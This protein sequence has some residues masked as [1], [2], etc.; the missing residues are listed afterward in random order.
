MPVPITS[1]YRGTA[2]F[3]AP[4]ASGVSHPTVGIRRFSAAADGTTGYQHRVTGV[5]DL[6]YLSWRYLGNS[7]SWWRLADTTAIRFPLDLRPGDVVAVPAD[8]QP[9]Q[10]GR[11]RSF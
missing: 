8:R 11:G 1:R 6:E 3:D 10:L 5:E 7:E 4:D 2:L 9:P